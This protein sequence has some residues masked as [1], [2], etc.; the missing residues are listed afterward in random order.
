MA[1]SSE[2]AS[3]IRSI[4]HGDSY[5]SPSITKLLVEE[6]QHGNGRASHD[7][8]EQ[9]TDRERDVLKLV[10]EGYTT[11][12]IAEMLVVSP[13]TIEG[14]MTSLMAKLG[15]HNRTELIKYALRKGII[16]V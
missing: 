3:G 7:P 12:K 14:H 8:Y 10:A 13:K 1:A 2:L 6:Y 5:L 4:H 15:I 11:Q 16:T 9:L